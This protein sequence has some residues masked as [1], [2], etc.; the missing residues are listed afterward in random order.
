MARAIDKL[1]ANC[2][3]ILKSMRVWSD[4]VPQDITISWYNDDDTVETS[5]FGNAMKLNVGN[6]S[7]NGSTSNPHGVTKA[8]VGLS[9][10]DNTS[11]V[12]KPLSMA[13]A[14]ALGQK[15]NTT[16]NH[17]LASLSE[18]SYTSLTDKPVIHNHANKDTL[19]K[20]GEDGNGN[21]TYNGVAV[22]TTVAQRDV[23]DGLDSADNT[24]SLA[25]SVGPTLIGYLNGKENSFTKNN[26][27]NKSF[28]NTSG[29]VS[30]GSH[31]HALA[32][33]SEKNYN[34]LDNKP[35]LTDLHSHTNKTILDGIGANGVTVT[36]S[37]YDLLKIKRFALAS[38]LRDYNPTSR[39]LLAFCEETDSLYHYAVTDGIGAW[40]KLG[41]G[42]KLL[43]PGQGTGAAGTYVQDWED[44]ADISEHYISSRWG[45]KT[46]GSEAGKWNRKSGTTPSSGTGTQNP[47]SGTYMVYG[48]MSSNGHQELLELETT[49]FRVATHLKFYFQMEGSQCGKFDVRG[50]SGD[51]THILHYVEGDQGSPW[52]EVDVDLTDMEIEKIIFRYKDAT[53][54]SADICLD[55]I[56]ITS[57]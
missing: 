50:I 11:D 53:G 31:S 21:P 54:Y 14:N 16:H 6:T 8:Q 7:H 22:D 4:P 27:F 46:D 20:F 47:Y 38:V 1:V 43:V 44:V 52:H 34:S 23:Y 36:Y 45:S 24:I 56:T 42:A 18:R 32:S 9:N 57:V 15:S 48:E 19:D 29:T 2:N 3:S 39:D 30:E 26:A 17:T 49:N 40:H 12:D 33:L 25:A 41:V 35:D 55:K 37:G 5:T 13:A 51:A 28:G 10:V